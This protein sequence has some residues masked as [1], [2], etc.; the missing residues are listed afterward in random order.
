MDSD[1]LISNQYEN[2]DCDW[3]VCSSRKFAKPKEITVHWLL[4]LYPNFE[5]ELLSD[6]VDMI[7]YGK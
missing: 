1:M 4:E 5:E 7:D 6:I 2:G 3:F